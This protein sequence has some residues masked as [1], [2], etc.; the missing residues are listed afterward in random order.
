MNKILYEKTVKNFYRDKKQHYL[1][2][3]N[4]QLRQRYENCIYVLVPEWNNYVSKPLNLQP[5]ADIKNEKVEKGK[6]DEVNRNR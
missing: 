2:Q 6:R 3:K 4:Q 1:I 5:I